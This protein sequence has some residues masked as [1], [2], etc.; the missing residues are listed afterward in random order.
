MF[1][2]QPIVYKAKYELDIILSLYQPIV[3]KTKGKQG[4][5]FDSKCQ[6]CLKAKN[7]VCEEYDMTRGMLVNN[8]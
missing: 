1:F 6:V 4:I 5:Y 8:R 7:L 2:Y 3:N